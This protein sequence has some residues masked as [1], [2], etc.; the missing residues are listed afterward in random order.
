MTIDM[1]LLI[2]LPVILTLVF[3]VPQI[4]YEHQ[5]ALGD[6]KLTVEITSSTIN[7]P[8]LA[9]NDKF[10]ISVS[11]IGDLDGDGVNDIAV[12]AR[13]DGEG[14]VNRGTIHIIFLNVNGS[15]KNIVEINSSTVNGPI[16][17][18]HDYFGTSVSNIGDLDGDG[19]NDIAVGSDSEGGV[20]R[21]AIHIIFLNNDGSPKSTVEINSNTVNGPILN[22]GDQFGVSVANIGDIDGDGVNDIA[23]GADIDEDAGGLYR[24][25]IH[26]IFLNNDGTPKSTV[27]INSSTVNGPVLADYDYFGTSVSNIGDLDGDGINDIAVGSDSEGGVVRGAIHIIFLNNDGTPKSTIEINSSTING[28]IL[29]DGDYF[30]TSVS[31]IG[32]LDG[33]GVNDIAVGATGDDTGGYNRGTIHIIF[34]EGVI[35]SPQPVIELFCG[36]LESYYNVINGTESSD[37]L[38]GTISP[39][40]I[41]GNG[42]NDMINTRGDNNCI[43]AGDGD[44]F[45]LA[46]ND[47][48]TVYGGAGNDSIMLNGTGIAYAE[49][50]DDTTYIILPSAGHL[51]DGGN[52]SDLC[53]ANG[54][55]LINTANCEI[56]NP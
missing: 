2:L 32:D 7:G 14:G 34:L 15:P 45:V 47:G 24:G 29:N 49:D 20:V 38:V 19:I 33:N 50:G 26:I 40:L 25:T 21:G 13:G 48:N 9:N 42:G 46:I 51:I 35:L 37:Y 18:D 43:Y 52:D 28:P 17:N 1:K 5:S 23:V 22:D 54:K 31:N 41:F 36:E 4:S 55:Q 16:L 11:D 3:F 44:D 12:G 6:V 56:I 30:G 39:D 53:I 27:E 8:I 10:G